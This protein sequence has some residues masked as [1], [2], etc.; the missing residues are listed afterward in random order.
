MQPMIYYYERTHENVKIYVNSF[1]AL[2]GTLDYTY[3]RTTG[4]D[5]GTSLAT[6]TTNSG[7]AGANGNL[8]KVSFEISTLCGCIPVTVTVLTEYTE[9]NNNDFIY[10]TGSGG[11]IKAWSSKYGNL[12]CI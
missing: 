4:V 9:A 8:G 6:Q 11:Q 12:T 5:T 3:T 7:T 2:A 1:W 10:S